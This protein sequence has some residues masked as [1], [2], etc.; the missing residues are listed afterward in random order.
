[1]A[2]FVDGE[3]CLTIACQRRLNRPSPAYR[4]FV[5]VTNTNRSCLLRFCRWYAGDIYQVHEK[6][7]DKLGKKWADAYCW[8][9]PASVV[10]RFLEDLLPYLCVKR[11][12][13]LVILEFIATKNGFARGR[14][15]P[16]QR[17]GSAPLTAKEIA[18]RERLK[19]RVQCLNTKGQYARRSARPP[20]A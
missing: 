8:Y 19:R 17:G 11:K 12:Q 6:R 9:C 14:Y 5:T 18:H 4:A 1:M 16:G 3:G 7:R 10:K 15:R 2:G 20:S 13:A